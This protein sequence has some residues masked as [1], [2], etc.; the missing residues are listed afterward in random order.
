MAQ[1]LGLM[2]Q[3]EVQR[4]EVINR[5]KDG[6]LEQAHAAKLLGLSVRQ[7]KRL[8]RRVREQGW[9][10]LVSRRRGRPSHR[11]ICAERREHYMRVVRSQYA[12]FGP[13]LAHEYLQRE[14]GFEWS[15]ETLR[16]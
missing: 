14:H 7:V 12:D 5:V 13:Q 15:V 2:S 16:G 8:C 3:K 6:G 1:E 9:Q 10:G 4:L 11:R